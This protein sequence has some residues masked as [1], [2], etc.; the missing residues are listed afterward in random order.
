MKEGG[1]NQNELVR[2]VQME[3]CGLGVIPSPV[4]STSERAHVWD[5]ISG[6]QPG[7]TLAVP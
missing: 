6:S 3:R 5:L 1:K 4:P 2:L 7:D